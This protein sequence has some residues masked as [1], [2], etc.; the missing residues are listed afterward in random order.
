MDHRDIP[1]RKL[2]NL[3]L[4]GPPLPAPD[5]VVRWLVAVQSTT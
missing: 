2:H 1:G 3:R 4:W 5:E